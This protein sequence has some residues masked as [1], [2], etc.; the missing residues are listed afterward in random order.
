MDSQDAEPQIGNSDFTCIIVMRNRRVHT[1]LP[2]LP[3][4][5]AFQS[6]DLSL[7]WRSLTH[8][9]HLCCCWAQG[10]ILGTLI[11]IYSATRQQGPQVAAPKAVIKSLL[12]VLWAGACLSESCLSPELSSLSLCR[13]DR[14]I[15][16][17]HPSLRNLSFCCLPPFPK[18][19]FSCRPSSLSTG[20]LS[21][22]SVCWG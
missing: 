1:S 8:P 9:A 12:W 17:T 10:P 3:E 11:G 16:G 21:D 4:D 5:Q 19:L 13:H 18:Y 2:D 7:N 20:A 22:L 14:C 15:S 6:L